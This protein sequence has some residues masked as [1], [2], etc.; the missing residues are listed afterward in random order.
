MS[1]F[2]ST[3]TS[4]CASNQILRLTPSKRDN[5]LQTC[6]RSSRFLTIL[7]NNAGIQSL[8]PVETSKTNVARQ[9]FDVNFHGLLD[10]T[11]VFLPVVREGVAK[12][13]LRT[14]SR[15]G[16]KLNFGGR[17]INVGSVAGF[18]TLPFFGIYAATKAAVESLTDALR[19]EVHADDVSVILI[20]PGAVLTEIE[21]KMDRQIDEQV[22]I[23]ENLGFENDYALRMT[24]MKEV[25]AS[26]RNSIIYFILGSEIVL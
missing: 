19:L 11:R 21:S 16:N 3:L 9:A 8:S 17:V 4:D 15:G 25:R 2:L 24:K 7:I 26:M 13:K 22:A 1:P 6:S 10:V 23:A 14:Q 18:T 5:I 12:L 20:Q